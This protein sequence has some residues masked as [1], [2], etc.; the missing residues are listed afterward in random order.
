[1]E[2]DNKNSTSM[3]ASNILTVSTADRGMYEYGSSDGDQEKAFVL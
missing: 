3:F 2:Y 1:M